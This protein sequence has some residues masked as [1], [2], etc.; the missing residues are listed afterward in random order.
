MRSV[1]R[2][3]S[4]PARASRT[5]GSRSRHV[6]AA[7]EVVQGPLGQGVAGAS[8]AGGPRRPSAEDVVRRD[9]PADGGARVVDHDEQAAVA[10]LGQV[11]RRLEEDAGQAGS[12]TASSQTANFDAG[13]R[14]RQRPC[15]KANA[16]SPP[17]KSL[18]SWFGLRT[19]QTWPP[20]R[21][22]RA[23]AA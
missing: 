6:A 14:I 12:A 9:Q 21:V 8:S 23:W 20:A 19:R 18:I 7:G 16:C 3:P 22:A 10:A 11:E 13:S 5:E 17:A 4:R 2:A 15:A 1:A